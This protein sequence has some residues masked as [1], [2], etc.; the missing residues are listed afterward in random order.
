[1]TAQS[2]RKETEAITTKGESQLQPDDRYCNPN[3]KTD[4]FAAPGDVADSF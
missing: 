3:A 4:Y 1:M 2:G